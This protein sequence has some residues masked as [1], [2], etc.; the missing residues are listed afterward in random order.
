MLIVT[1]HRLA[2][3]IGH[4]DPS[5]VDALGESA[6]VGTDAVGTDAV[7]TDPVGTDPVG[8]DPVG[9]DPVGTDPVGTDA[10][11]VDALIAQGKEALDALSAR[12][13]FVRGWCARAAD[14]DG[15]VLLA[16]EWANVGSWRRAMSPIDVRMVVLP[17]MTTAVDEPTAFIVEHGTPGTTIDGPLLTSG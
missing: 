12:P 3:A 15:L 6:P 7:G 5:S 4:V 9:T 1:R 8:T 14:D 11:R 13:G 16:T 17:F 2:A 10:A